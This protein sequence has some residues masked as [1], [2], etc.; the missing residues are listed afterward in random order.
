MNYALKG[1]LKFFFPGSGKNETR[2]ELGDAEKNKE[3]P[4]G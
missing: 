3:Q 1:T 4:K 2:R